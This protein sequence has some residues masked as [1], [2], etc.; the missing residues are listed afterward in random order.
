MFQNKLTWL[1][2]AFS[3]K[4]LISNFFTTELVVYNL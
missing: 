1:V 2:L 4:V 3:F